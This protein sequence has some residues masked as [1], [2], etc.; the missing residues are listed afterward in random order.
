MITITNLTE[1]V[2]RGV[3]SMET[4]KRGAFS[5]FFQCVPTKIK[6]DELIMVAPSRG[7]K[8]RYNSKGISINKPPTLIT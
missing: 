3:G 7:A 4:N 2:T 8:M 6:N 5:P 1:I